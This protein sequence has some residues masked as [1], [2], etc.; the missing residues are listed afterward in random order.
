LEANVAGA[1]RYFRLLFA[2]GRFGLLGEMAFRGNFIVKIVVELLW[3]SFLLVFYRTIFTK[4][5]MVAGWTEAEYLFFVGCYF[6]VESLIETMFLSNC[7]EFAELVRSGNLD[8]YLLRPI[9]EQFLVTCRN[10]DW[11]TVPSVILGVSVM[12]FALVELQWTFNLWLVLLFSGVLICGLAIAYGCLVMLTASSV[13]LVRNQ[14]LFELWWLFTSLARY[15]KEIFRGKW[16]SPL[17]WFFTFIIPVLLVV[18][19]PARTMVKAIN[20][21][22]LAFMAVAAVVMLVVSRRVFQLALK[23]YR[24]ASS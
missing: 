22:L 23:R 7:T 14:S 11:T 15:P 10:I 2:F 12:S 3:L 5:S 20:P 9:D 6:T 13:W 1:L 21:W 24:S 17:G 8:F 16:A 4:T 19:M 18:N